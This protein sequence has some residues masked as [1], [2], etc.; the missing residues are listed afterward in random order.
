MP[1][2]NW[3]FAGVATEPA[4]DLDMLLTCMRPFRRADL[5]RCL[6][7]LKVLLIEVAGK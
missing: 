7:S 6:D 2:R 3:Q 5:G 4:V 1:V